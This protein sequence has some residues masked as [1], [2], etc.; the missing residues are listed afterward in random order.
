[1][2]CLLAFAVE[3]VGSQLLFGIS[4]ILAAEAG[5]RVVE[6]LKTVEARGCGQ[7]CTRSRSL[8]SEVGNGGDGGSESGELKDVVSQDE[9]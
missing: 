5:E 4:A 7:G 1:V 9:A 3:H 8:W 6:G 2:P